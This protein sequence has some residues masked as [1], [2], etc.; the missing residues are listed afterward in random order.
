MESISIRLTQPTDLAL[1]QAIEVASGQAFRA[2]RMDAIADDPPLSL[3]SLMVYHQAEHAWVAVPSKDADR[4]IAYILVYTVHND[5]LEGW[6][7]AFIHQVT[8]SPD[9][10]RRGIGKALIEHVADWARKNGMRALDLTT[11]VDVPWNKPYYERL[12]FRVVDEEALLCNHA[13]G[14]RRV[15]LCERQDSVLG[16]WPRVAMRKL[17]QD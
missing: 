7:C 4:P 6:R 3:E 17:L 1:I 16:N 10:S 14:L 2:L 15:I 12:G 9:Y 5:G 8:V 13:V 11:F